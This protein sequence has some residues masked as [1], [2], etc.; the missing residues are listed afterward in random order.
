MNI[1]KTAVDILLP[2]TPI[3]A[4]FLIGCAVIVGICNDKKVTKLV[5]CTAVGIAVIIAVIIGTNA[6]LGKYITDADK[7][8]SRF[9]RTVSDG[10]GYS[11]YY[12]GQAVSGS[13]LGITEDNIDDYDIIYD[14]DNKT[15]K[16]MHK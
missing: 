10:S 12:N 2:V 7:T 9:T 15:V 4:I 8:Y 1:S 11:V 3:L 16:I 5:V 6:F 13:A 14:D